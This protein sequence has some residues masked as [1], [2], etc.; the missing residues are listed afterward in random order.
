MRAIDWRRLLTDE[1]VPFIE[2]GPNVKGGEINI[3]C[4]FCGS[5]DPSQHMGLNLDTGWW[6]CWRNKRRH[7]GKSPVR[8]LMA[9][10]RIPYWKARE[11]AGLSEDYV[12]PEGFNAV[13]A[14]LL[15]RLQG[16]T[17]QQLAERPE[18]RFLGFPR[19]FQSLTSRSARCGR[20]WA[21]LEGRGFDDVA[22][23]AEVYDLRFA[24]S[25]QW[26]NRIIIPYF[27]DS[28][29]VTW[30]ARAIGEAR[31]RY[32]DL[33]VEESLV[34]PKRTLFNYDAIAR[35]G[36]IL[37]VVE[38]PVDALKLD[39]YGYG[40]GVRAVAL[41]TNS[42]NEEQIFMLEEASDQFEEL[43]VMMDASPAGMVDSM[44]I[45]EE[46]SFIFGTIRTIGVPY[47][48]KD[49]GAMTAHQAITFTD[50]LTQRRS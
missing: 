7:S 23:L 29:L 9:L 41:S 18:A 6:A 49:A 27:I 16:D 32:L 38:G 35:G 17:A 36:R 10:L 1:G 42:L 25:G 46:L 33:P 8:L 39:F 15:G 47:G 31:L 3:K 20:H 21:Y 4:P 43:G 24:S 2:R 12:D 11:L 22:A 37:I 40:V 14:R 5:A 30:T 19:E 34:P 28:D 50:Q 48:L 44:K 45:K 13:A 26:A